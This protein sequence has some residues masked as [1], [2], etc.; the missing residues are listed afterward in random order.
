MYDWAYSGT[1]GSRDWQPENRGQNETALYVACVARTYRKAIDDYFISKEQYL[2]NM[3]WYQAEIGKCTYRQFTTGFYFEKPNEN[4][5]IYDSSTY[6]NEAVYLGTV[7]SVDERGFARF[8][9]KNKF[10]VGDQ[11]ELMNQMVEI[12]QLPCVLCI[13]WREKL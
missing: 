2:A 3:A 13:R 10:C 9:Q 6:V 1:C 4:T 12:V 8:E 11:I 5:Q 7:D